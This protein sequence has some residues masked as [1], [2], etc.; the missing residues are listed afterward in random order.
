MTT[1]V[2]LI[3]TTQPENLEQ[4]RTELGLDESEKLISYCARVSNPSNQSNFNTAEK[5]LG[6]CLK[7]KHWSIFEMVNL[8]FE[9]E[10]TR[11]I[12][13]Q[14]L[15]HGFK[16][17]EFSQRYADPTTSLG[18]VTREPRKQDPKNRQNSIMFNMYDSDDNLLRAE[19]MK[20]LNEVIDLAQRVYKK[21]IDA[22][23]A[24]EQARV[25]LPEGL[26]V[27][28]MYVNGYLRNWITYC[29]VRMKKGTQEEHREIA[30]QVWEI[31]QRKYSFLSQADAKD[32]V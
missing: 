6:Y 17:Q 16:Y 29:A 31:L 25:V 1:S 22:G 3:A 12:G 26:T 30:F 9:V 7:N 15:R 11:D 32:L 5:L 14:M 13:R 18:F 27:S 10:T 24:K 28:R 23:I 20:D 2:K 4:F 21:A 8:V 19:W